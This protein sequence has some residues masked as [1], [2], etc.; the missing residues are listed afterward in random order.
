MVNKLGR[1]AML[2]AAVLSISV[3]MFVPAMAADTRAGETVN[4]SKGEVV[5]DDLYLVGS[6]VVMD[7]AVNG[8][9]VAFG[10]QVIINGDVTGSV[11]VAAQTVIIRGKVSNS[12][13]AAGASVT[14]IGNTGGDLV[15]TA[16]TVN[17]SPG[18]S[19][20]RDLLVACGSVTTDGPVTR[21]IKGN[22]G[23]MVLNGSAGGD[24]LIDVGELKLG[25]QALIIG[26]LTYTSERDA[27]ISNTGAVKGQVTHNVP[28]K[29]A[30]AANPFPQTIGTAVGALGSAVI[31]IIIGFFIILALIKYAA[32]LLTGIVI[33]LIARKR[34]AGA[35]AALYSKPWECLGWGAL[36]AFLTPIA[37][38]MAFVSII[39]IPLGAGVL[40]VYIP[41]LYLGHLVTAVLLGRLMLRQSTDAETPGAL[42]GALALGLL[43]IYV[44]GMIPFLCV[45]TN[46]AVILFGFGSIVYYIKSGA[47]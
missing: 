12:V 9:V 10:N 18:S 40:A 31:G 14:M 37:I 2:F 47:A 29:K 20:G 15:A 11:I 6:E 42:I 7:G 23:R 4:V 13:R 35:A 38:A 24:V 30:P 33:I 21:N 41:C 28:P 36:G 27:S 17:V 39:G 32:A 46:L 5:N 34:V 45:L 26:S 1:L 16:G 19:I 44:V 3:L 25:P 22:A 43:V 8:D